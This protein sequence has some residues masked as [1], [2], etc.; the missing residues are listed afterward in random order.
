M[1]LSLWAVPDEATC[2]F[3]VRFYTLLKH[4]AGRYEAL[5]SI[6]REFRHHENVV[7]R[8]PFYWGAWQ[9][10]GDGGPIEGL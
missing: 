7:W 5:V 3:M 9:L 1:L 10:I 2:E 8:H 6:Q 4:G